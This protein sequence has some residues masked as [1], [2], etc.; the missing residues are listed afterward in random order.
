MDHVDIEVSDG[1]ILIFTDDGG[2]LEM[3]VEPGSEGVIKVMSSRP[4]SSITVSGADDEGRLVHALEE[5]GHEVSMKAAV[6]TV[7]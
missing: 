3:T 6:V 4:P 7:F 5:L 2:M 1:S